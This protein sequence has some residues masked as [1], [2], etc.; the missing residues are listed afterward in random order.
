MKFVFGFGV[1]KCWNLDEMIE[2]W[3]PLM[4]PVVDGV[5]LVVH[6]ASCSYVVQTFC[7]PLVDQAARKRKMKLIFSFEW[8]KWWTF[9]EIEG[10]KKVTLMEEEDFEEE[11][12]DLEG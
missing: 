11:E 1:G 2:L 6:G 8:I 4:G 9:T 7:S 5:K 12:G 3:I 10:G